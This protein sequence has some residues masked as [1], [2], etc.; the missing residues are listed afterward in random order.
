MERKKALLL[1]VGGRAAPDVLALFCVQPHLVAILTS[2]EGW[3]GELAFREIASSLPNHEQLLATQQVESYK[4]EEI[5]QACSDIYQSYP[6]TKWNWTFSIASCP[7]IMA[8]AAYEVA[9]E[10]GIP[11]LYIDSQHE[12]VKSFVADIRDIPDIGIPPERLFQMTVQ[13][14][15]KVY[16][17]E[18]RMLGQ[19]QMNY[20]RKAEGWGDIARVMAL[21]PHTLDFTK[22]MR[23]KPAWGIVPFP[24]ALAESPLVRTLIGF[25]AVK[26]ERAS[27]GSFTCAFT[28]EHFAKFLGTGD[29]LEVY[30]WHEAKEAKFASDYQWGYKIKSTAENELDMACTYQAQLI[31]VECKTDKNPFLGGTR[32]LDSINGKAEMLGGNYVTKI[33]VTNASKEQEGYNNFYNQATLRRIVV[34]TA[35]DLPQI[36]S[37][38]EKEAKTPR[39]PRI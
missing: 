1:V 23:E 2:K 34:F 12:Y 35:E 5:S 7:K 11:C 18:P 24:S 16:R 36:G 30:V 31:F 33:F 20:R 38:L 9:K 4:F 8:V 13:E 15:M 28:S 29:W 19:N 17:R 10:N 14:Y 21:S 27:N 25:Q 39:Y 22:L 26:I 37:L 3:N 32:Y 6:K